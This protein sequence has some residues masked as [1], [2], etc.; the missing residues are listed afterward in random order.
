MSEWPR[1][2]DTTSA[3]V[4]GGID[5]V[6]IDVVPPLAAG[7]EHGEIVFASLVGP[8]A[9][10][11]V[12]GFIRES[13]IGCGGEVERRA[14]IGLHIDVEVD[15]TVGDGSAGRREIEP[16]GVDLLAEG[17][18]ILK[19][20][21]QFPAEGQFVLRQWQNQGCRFAAKQSGT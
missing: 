10:A 3:V 14:P 1:E 13:G 12:G 9:F 21:I 16:Q 15:G 7:R 19:E 17:A 11:V 6:E 4:A 5:D 18:V 20:E 2:H 8:A